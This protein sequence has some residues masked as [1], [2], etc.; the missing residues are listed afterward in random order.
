MRS[1]IVVGCVVGGLALFAG[2]ANAQTALPKSQPTT[3]VV[4]VDAGEWG[5]APTADIQ[6]VLQSAANE[7]WANFP[8]WPA[9]RVVV[10]HS[11]DVPIT[12]YQ[13][14]PD[15]AIV[16]RLAVTDTYWAQ[17]AF[18]F[19]HELCHIAC[20]Y[21]R[22]Q[23]GEKHNQ[24]FEESLCEVASLFVLK[25]M[26]AAWEVSPPYPNWKSFAPHL[27]KYCEERRSQ[28]EHTLPEGETFITW[29][30]K[31]HQ[32][33]R[34]NPVMRDK[35]VIIASQLLPLF[36]AHPDAWQAVSYLNLQKNA[37]AKEFDAY[38]LDWQNDCPEKYKGFV[39]Q[40]AEQFGVTLR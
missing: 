5:T 33:L 24:W 11:K 22:T 30:A 18:Q 19:A 6:K 25:R 8:D 1:K 17:F 9:P 26:A 23:T 39:R 35:N 10:E 7:F 38:L 32:A 34:A 29:F 21:E 15:G 28:K 40:I 2:V 3:M 16:V 4:T 31:N 12:L 13:K 20:N 27:A 36:E 14:R 37:K